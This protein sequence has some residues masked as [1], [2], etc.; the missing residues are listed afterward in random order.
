MDVPPLPVTDTQKKDTEQMTLLVV[1]HFVF[2][3]ICLA[4]IGF[5]FLHYSIFHQFFANPDMWK[6]QK[7]APPKELV[8]FFKY[9]VWF[10]V[11]MGGL[12]LIDLV[13]NVASAFCLMNRKGR[14]FSMVVAGLNCVQVPFGTALGVFTIVVLTRDSVRRMFR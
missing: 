6:G 1:F 8:E 12:I 13:L 4:G 10:Y 2:A 5:L 14:M 9:F 11:V 3:V 7:N